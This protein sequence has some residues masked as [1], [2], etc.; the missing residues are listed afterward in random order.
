[1][2]IEIS[3]T[4]TRQELLDAVAHI[5]REKYGAQIPPTRAQRLMFYG[6]YDEDSDLTL[7]PHVDRE[8]TVA[9]RTY[10]KQEGCRIDFV[11]DEPTR[12]KEDPEE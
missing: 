6:G 10:W 4:L 1:M 8:Q 3:V 12:E 11:L 2:G 7:K 9:E 5:A